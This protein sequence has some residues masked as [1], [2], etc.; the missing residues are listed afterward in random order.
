MAYS[1]SDAQLLNLTHNLTVLRQQHGL[2]K[3]AMARLLHTSVRTITRLE[4]NE[5]PRGLSASILVYAHTHF[6]V[7]PHKLLSEY[8]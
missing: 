5:I 7:P 4:N 3:T 2:T 8:L 1:K 6:H